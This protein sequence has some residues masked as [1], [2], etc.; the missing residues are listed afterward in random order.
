MQA[1]RTNS[2]V[3]LEDVVVSTSAAPVYFPLRKFEADGRQHFLVDGG[4]AANNPTLLAI[5]EAT[6]ILEK[7]I[8][9]SNSYTGPDNYDKFLVLSL[10]TGSAEKQLG[11]NIGQGGLLS[12]VFDQKSGLNPLFDIM[13]RASDDMLSIYTSLLLGNHNTPRNYLRIQDYSM[14]THEEKID[15]ASFENLW[16]LEK[17]GKNLLT[18]SVLVTH[19]DTGLP[20]SHDMFLSADQSESIANNKAALIT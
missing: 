4:L 17:V 3:R 2:E 9:T 20:V 19:P 16:R 11:Q 7:E 12:W 8:T 15:N 18:R 10:G 1:K 13:F 14:K 5:R 6:K